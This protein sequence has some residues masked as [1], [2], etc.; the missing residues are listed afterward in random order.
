MLPAGES[1]A[2]QAMK[3]GVRGMHLRV[4]G[5]LTMMLVGDGVGWQGT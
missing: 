3:P 1:G 2:P 4:V 5:A